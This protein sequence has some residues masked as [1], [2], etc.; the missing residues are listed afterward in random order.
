MKTNRR[1][2]RQWEKKRTPSG[3][4]DNGLWILTDNIVSMP[5][6]MINDAIVAEISLKIGTTHTSETKM[7]AY[8]VTYAGNSWVI[9]KNP[10]NIK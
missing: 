2:F 6:N 3:Y 8:K 5:E 4:L 9:D 10:L 1:V 7:K